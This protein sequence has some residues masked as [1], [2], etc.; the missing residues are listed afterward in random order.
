MGFIKD[1]AGAIWA[2]LF[3]VAVALFPIWLIKMMVWSIFGL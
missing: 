2:V 3:I 1:L